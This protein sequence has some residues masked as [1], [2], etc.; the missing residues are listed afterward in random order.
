[1]RLHRSVSQ[2]PKNTRPAWAFSTALPSL[3]LFGAMATA[4]AWGQQTVS[5]LPR[6]SPP[7]KVSQ[8][9]GMTEVEVSYHR[10]GVRDRD[11][12][13][14]LVPYGQVWRAGANENTTVTFSHDVKIE[15]QDLRA[16]TYGFHLEPQASGPWTAIFSTD[17]R[18]WGS[19][20]YDAAN[21]ALRV[22]V[23]ARGADDR[24]Q[25]SYRFDD[26]STTGATLVLHWA[27]KEVPIRIEVDTHRQVIDDFKAQLTGLPAFAWQGWNSAA[28]YCVRSGVYFEE[29]RQWA[30]RSLSMS[31]QAQNLMTHAGLLALEGKNDQIAAVEEEAL[32]MADEAQVNAMGYTYLFQRGDAAKAVEL[33]R[34]NVKDHPE[35]WNAHDSLGE[36]LA[37]L[38]K[39]S[40]AVKAYEKALAMAPEAQKGRIQGVLKGLREGK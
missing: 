12:W 8:G 36:G 7:A 15:G 19:F 26:G 5:G 30:D 33:F 13:G 16:G 3:L 32:G 9:I 29:C 18:A 31:R 6:V 39:T 11:I 2:S 38:G 27:D 20:A 40:D 10:P 24:E 17:H 28:S 14:T 35:S 34:R 22:K 1:M 21:D 23:E 4:P 37:A 25:L